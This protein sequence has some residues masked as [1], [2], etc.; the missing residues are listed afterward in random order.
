M[1]AHP[2]YDEF[3]ETYDIAARHGSFETPALH[4][5][6]WYDTLLE[7]TLENFSGLRASARTE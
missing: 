4:V 1:L 3:W 7:G 2:S 6:G 5:T